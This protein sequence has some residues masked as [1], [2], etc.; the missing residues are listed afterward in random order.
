[1]LVKWNSTTVGSPRTTISITTWKNPLFPPPLENILPRYL[2]VH[3][4]C[5]RD[6]CHIWKLSPSS[7]IVQNV[8]PSLNDKETEIS[9]KNSRLGFRDQESKI[10]GWCRYFS[11]KFSKNVI[12]TSKLKFGR[13]SGILLSA[14]V[15]SYLQIAYSWHETRQ[16]RDVLVNCIVAV[17]K[18]SR[19]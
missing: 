18:V 5:T 4:L 2:D 7:T 19:Q 12:I 15:G 17:F 9:S 16:T 1:M 13:I 6:D 10:C 3:C 8:S 14:L 11:K